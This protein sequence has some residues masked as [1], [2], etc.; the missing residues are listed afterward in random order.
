[1]LIIDI[2]I[3][4][5]LGQRE[6]C[7]TNLLMIRRQVVLSVYHEAVVSRALLWNIEAVETSLS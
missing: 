2:S 4:I 6:P 1:M 3:L 7:Y 5:L